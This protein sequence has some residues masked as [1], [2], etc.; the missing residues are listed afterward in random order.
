ME[1]LKIQFTDEREPLTDVAAVLAALGTLTEAALWVD[2]CS[3]S[4]RTLGLVRDRLRDTVMA[5][6]H[7][8]IDDDAGLLR[9]ALF[10]GRHRERLAG[11]RPP[12][13]W[14]EARGQ[15][16]GPWL[17]RQLSEFDD[18]TYADL[19]GFAQVRE[20][21]HESPIK[22][23]VGVAGATAAATAALGPLGVAPAVLLGL[24]ETALWA[25]ERWWGSQASVADARARI[26]TSEA[27]IV[28]EQLTQRLL[29][30]AAEVE[31]PDAAVELAIRAA[32]PAVLDLG[33]STAIRSMTREATGE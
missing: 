9:D 21:E 18:H 8:P 16:Y 4:T 14:A 22:V 26:A 20:L 17:R 19:A 33:T 3:P 7:R 11:P 1:L 27:H 13:G 23:T 30:A 28:R 29:E 31:V 5:R 6:G 12:S 25:R 2:I 10:D 24:Y 15:A 32:L